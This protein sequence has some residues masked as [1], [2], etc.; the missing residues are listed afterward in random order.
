MGGH[1]AAAAAA[2][3]CRR[4]SNGAAGVFM[5]AEE[6]GAVITA[7]ACGVETAE[8]V[9]R[10]IRWLQAPQPPVRPHSYPP[11]LSAS[12]RVR[13]CVW[14]VVAEYLNAVRHCFRRLVPCPPWSRRRGEIE[15]GVHPFPLPLFPSFLC[16]PC[17]SYFWSHRYV[18]SSTSCSICGHPARYLSPPSTDGK[19]RHMLSLCPFW[20]FPNIFFEFN[21]FRRVTHTLFCFPPKPIVVFQ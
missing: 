21:F 6:R 4:R 20:P 17:D 3:G 18:Y 19:S 10:R 2:A 11:T 9:E 1:G 5:C 7:S 12:L 14:A 13:V 15:H 8:A 16:A